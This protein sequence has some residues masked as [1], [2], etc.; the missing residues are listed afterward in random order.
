MATLRK[1]IM[2]MMAG[3]MARTASAILQLE[4]KPMIIEAQNPTVLAK[5]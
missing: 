4:L 3:K 1:I 5:T 2:T